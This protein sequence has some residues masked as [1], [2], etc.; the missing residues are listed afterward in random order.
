MVIRKEQDKFRWLITFE[1]TVMWIWKMTNPTM[2]R[3]SY[4]IVEYIICKISSHQF[5][6]I[7][8]TILLFI[9]RFKVVLVQ[10]PL[11]NRFSS[12]RTVQIAISLCAGLV[13]TYTSITDLSSHNFL[14]I[15][16]IK[17]SWDIL[18]Q[19]NLNTQQT[20]KCWQ[21]HHS[22]LLQFQILEWQNLKIYK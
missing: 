1:T 21:R 5:S 7:K 6:L 19:L 2:G 15:G 18:F 9:N 22:P 3:P 11:W 20:T 17:Q 4:V 12:I 16:T 10:N 14:F 13:S 8:M